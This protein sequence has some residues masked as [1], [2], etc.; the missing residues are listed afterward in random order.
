MV[1]FAAFLREAEATED[2]RHQRNLSWIFWI[3]SA[4]IFLLLIWFARQVGSYLGCLF[5]VVPFAVAAYLRDLA[6]QRMEHQRST[7]DALQAHYIEMIRELG[8]YSTQGTLNERIHPALAPQLETA[9]TSYFQVKEWLG[10]KGSVN[11]LGAETHRE[12]QQSIRRA[13]REVV[14]ALHGQYRPTGMQRKKWDAMVSS[15]TSATEAAEDLARVCGLI[16]QLADIAKKSESL[17]KTITLMDQLNA[18]QQAI[19]ELEE[20]SYGAIKA[21][22]PRKP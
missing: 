20:T 21:L 8:R 1:R 9:A 22:P 5:F 6:K 10:T 7:S 2:S 13:M 17:G 14:F 12:V 19:S 4:A 18:V 16:L 3:V 15:D 11:V